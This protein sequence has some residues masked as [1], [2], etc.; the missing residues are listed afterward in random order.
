MGIRLYKYCNKNSK[1]GHNSLVS[2]I[3]PKSTPLCLLTEGF[4][5]TRQAKTATG[6]LRYGSWPISS[7]LDSSCAGQKIQDITGIDCSAPI[8][9]NIQEALELNPRALLIGI[10]PIGGDLPD[11]WITLIKTAIINKMH[12]INGLHNFLADIPELKN[13]ADEHQVMLWDVRD[14]SIYKASKDN[15]VAKQKSRNLNTK[16]ITMVGSDCN[17]GKM[18]TALELQKAALRQGIP[19][20]FVATGQTGIM[21]S[22][23]GIPLD[24]IICDFASGAM[25]RAI[26]EACGVFDLSQKHYV[27]VEGQG[28]LLHP[29]YSGVTLS[30]VHGSNP[31]AMILCH[32]AGIEEIQGGYNVKIPNMSQLISIYQ[33]AVSWIQANN[34]AKIIGISINTSNLNEDQARAYLKSVKAETG[35]ESVDLIRF[36]GHEK[37]LAGI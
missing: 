28:S 16:I 33:E 21:I 15:Y 8:V 2:I 19:S 17:V 35:L 20:G 6:I 34:P 27:F 4:L 25:E 37:I 11:N 1:K 32:K 26:D 24:R 23:D 31:S 5:A 36:G 18:C 29:G 12:I 30:L 13:L 7:V 22:G 3:D 14:P 9:S 10:A